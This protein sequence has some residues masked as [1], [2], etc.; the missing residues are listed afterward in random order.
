MQ[1]EP[2]SHQNPLEEVNL[3]NGEG[4]AHPVFISKM[5]SSPIKD[6]L[7]ALLRKNFDV[8]TWHYKEMPGL[9]NVL[10]TY[11]LDIF[12]NSNPVKQPLRK[13]HR[14]L[15]EKIKEEVEKLRKVGFIHVI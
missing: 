1:D 7:I 11:H 6:E 10:V 3:K 8:F 15:E 13:H 5:L 9:D 4:P 2:K 14:D 12:P